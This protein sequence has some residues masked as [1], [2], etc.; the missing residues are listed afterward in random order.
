MN[1]EMNDQIQR[2][3]NNRLKKI[4]NAITLNELDDVKYFLTEEAY[5]KIR[6]KQEKSF[7]KQARLMYEEVNIDSVIQNIIEE[8]EEYK[9]QLI[10]T[11]KCLEYEKTMDGKIISG[12]NERRIEKK[13]PIFLRM[14][15]QSEKELIHR[16]QGCGVTLNIME[17]GKCPHCGRIVNSTDLDFVIESME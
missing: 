15:K 13:T 14:K 2:E 11:V 17:S 8:D 3:V 10:A 4:Y 16:C 5:K 12:T 9:V 7:T 1:E 6:S